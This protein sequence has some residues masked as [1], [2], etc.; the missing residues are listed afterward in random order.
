MAGQLGPH[1][2]PP[3]QRPGQLAQGSAKPKGLHCSVASPAPSGVIGWFSGESAAET[4]GQSPCI[5]PVPLLHLGQW[6][7]HGPPDSSTWAGRFYRPETSVW[8][9]YSTL[10]LISPTVLSQVQPFIHLTNLC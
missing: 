5:H 8:G 1:G 10:L 7:C 2:G 6:A 3:P 9:Q 4:P